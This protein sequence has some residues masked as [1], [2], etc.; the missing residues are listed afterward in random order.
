MSTVG[1]LRKNNEDNFLCEEKCREDIYSMEDETVFGTVS[2]EE[3]RMFAVFD[4]MGGEACGEVASLLAAQKAREFC[5]NRMEFE[6]YLYELGDILNRAV[7]EETAQRSLVLMGTTAAM[8]QFSKNDIYV[9]SAGDSR[10]YK[11]SKHELFQVS[12]DHIAHAYGKKALTKFLGMPNS[13]EPLK[14]F[15]AMGSYKVGDVYLLC[16]DGVT[17]MLTDS[18]MKTI[19]DKKENLQTLTKDLVSAAMEKGGVD[20]AT[21]ILMKIT[22]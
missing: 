13:D 21:A 7:A 19:L 10:I 15:F 8:I 5:Q 12:S 6:E 11:L 18:E 4:G 3:N 2:S 16:T 22:K 17:D 14:P 9:L 1:R 20:N